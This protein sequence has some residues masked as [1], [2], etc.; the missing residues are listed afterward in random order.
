[1]LFLIIDSGEH[2]TIQRTYWP[3][4][5]IVAWSDSPLWEVFWE[6]HTSD[7]KLSDRM[8][9]SLAKDALPD[10]LTEA[11][12]KAL[13]RR[14]QII[15]IQIYNCTRNKSIHEVIIDDRYF[16]ERGWKCHRGLCHLKWQCHSH[17][18]SI[19]QCCNRWQSYYVN[20]T[21]MSSRMNLMESFA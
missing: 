3:H 2:S 12:L 18:W 15:L 11:H 20:Q 14:V 6:F 7:R 4:S 9:S 8:R 13:D 19:Q 21:T 5:T 17:A 10:I 1:M 16:L